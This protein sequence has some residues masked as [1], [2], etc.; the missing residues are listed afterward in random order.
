MG[1]LKS[2]FYQ[3][4]C[5]VLVVAT[6]AL[7]FVYREQVKAVYHRL[8]GITPPPD[9]VYVMPAAEGPAG[10]SRALDAL[11]RRGGPAWV[12]LTA[13]Q[14]AALIDASL[15]RTGGRVLDSVS[16]GLLEGEIRVRGS[17]D[18]SG[19]P[20][21]MLGPLRGAVGAREPVVIGGP[22]R[23]DSAGRVLLEVTTLRLRDFPFPRSTIARILGAARIPG[24]EGALV[25]VP[26]TGP[27]GDVRVGPAA[28]RVYR[29]GAR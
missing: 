7:A 2:I 19:V 5:F 26:G 1:C 25:P 8:R 11:E 24:V 29:R 13:A 12:D 20:R 4:G 9:A 10:A 15:G 17:L 28:V 3:I 21:D 6:V 23:A 27:V 14:V 16:V 18:L 22:L